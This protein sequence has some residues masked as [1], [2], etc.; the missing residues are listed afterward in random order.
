MGIILVERK[1]ENV[2]LAKINYFALYPTQSS[3]SLHTRHF[4]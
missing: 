3:S 1:E 4:K 2:Q